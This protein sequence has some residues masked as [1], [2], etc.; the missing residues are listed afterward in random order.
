[1]F[2]INH[3]IR[4]ASTLPSEFYKS[5]E[6]FELSKE[7]VFAKTW[8]YIT[9]SEAVAGDRQVYPFTLLEKTLDEP[10]VF[11]RDDEQV[12]RCLSNVC[13]HRGK[14]IVEQPGKVR[15]LTCGYHG[16]CFRLDG[17]FK[18]MPAFEQT[19]NFPTAADHLAKVPFAAWAGMLFVSPDPAMTFE[20]WISPLTERIGWMNLDSLRFDEATS[21]DYYINANWALYCDNYLEGFHIPFVHPALNEALDFGSYSYEIYPYCN[22][23]VGIAK[24][25]EPCFDIPPGAPDHGK[26]IYAYYYWMFP[27]L[28]L[29]FY[30]W[31]LS[32]NVV[33][34]LGHDQTRVRFRT[35]LFEGSEVDRT[36]FAIDKTE[37]E[38][39]SVVESVQLGIRSRYYKSGRFSPTMEQGVHHFHTL[40][41][42]FLHQK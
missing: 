23:Q 32:M 35:Y 41:S 4:Q 39:E 13:T 11:V 2:S 25:G 27:N 19:E 9:D 10:L 7:A 22:L 36:T 6:V 8:H 17:S 29:N 21:K 34:P 33:E 42:H 3:N 14:I 40:I 38:D 31:G 15:M 5:R 18:S 20:D 30:P 28:M 37:M 24:E 1:M 12:L 16:R 26:R